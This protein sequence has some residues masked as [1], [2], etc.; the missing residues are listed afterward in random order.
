MYSHSSTHKT[1]DHEHPQ[2]RPNTRKDPNDP[3][4]RS[5]P[6]KTNQN[7]PRAAESKFLSQTFGDRPKDHQNYPKQKQHY[8]TSHS[9]YTA[10]P[11]EPNQADFEYSD[12]HS[13]PGELEA[14]QERSIEQSE[15]TFK[16]STFNEKSRQGNYRYRTEGYGSPETSLTLDF[17]TEEAGYSRGKHGYGFQSAEFETFEE[18]PRKFPQGKQN[19][20]YQQPRSRN[21]SESAS[22]RQDIPSSIPSAR[23]WTQFER[24]GPSTKTRARE[25]N[26]TVGSF[27]N[28]SKPSGNQSKKPK[29]RPK[30]QTAK[31]K[32]AS[33]SKS[34]AEPSAKERTKLKRFDSPGL[35]EYSNVGEAILE[36]ERLEN[37]IKAKDKLMEIMK[38]RHEEIWLKFQN[39]QEEL[40]QI[41]TAQDAR[42][43]ESQYEV[44]RLLQK[45]STLENEGALLRRENEEYEKSEREAHR[46]IQELNAQINNLQAD[47][48]TLAKRYQTKIETL[49]EK[50]KQIEQSSQIL[51][52][53]MGS[54]EASM[55]LRFLEEQNEELQKKNDLLAKM[56]RERDKKIQQQEQKLEESVRDLADSRINQTLQESSRNYSH[57]L[58]KYKDM[59]RGLKTE[60]ENLKMELKARPTM[61]H[62]ESRQRS[63]E[64][65]NREGKSFARESIA[66]P[67]GSNMYKRLISNLRA[68]L[69]VENPEDLV[70][71]VKELKSS[72]K[73]NAAVTDMVMKCA[74]PGYFT[75]KPSLKESWKFI[76]SIMEEYM[77][78]KKQQAG[79]SQPESDLETLKILKAVVDFVGAQSKAEIPSRVKRLVSEHSM[80]DV[81]VSKFKELMELDEATPLKDLDGILSDEL[82]RKRDAM[83]T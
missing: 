16:G 26:K 44:E 6:Q 69:D 49:L 12:Y 1:P 82:A 37:K 71:K 40:H 77:N 25:L 39:A 58:Q 74:P 45:L 65:E 5:N 64:S 53:P 43:K 4:F 23:S 55:Q 31:G 34:Q 8:Q 68:E 13:G 42:L 56:I 21:L 66:S 35:L 67:E 54:P 30:S 9:A 72:A 10:N 7:D 51:L 28:Y 81:I 46:K 61:R 24:P 70:S 73:F 17:S 78:L 50:I 41:R 14:V 11:S 63:V 2:S 79:G 60:N 22:K 80:M 48:T 32:G 27:G 75:E 47:K 29:Q 38:T 83:N 20:T 59:L 57:K 18:R 3:G 52:D 15:T 76:K 62:Q 36:I 19:V 33:K